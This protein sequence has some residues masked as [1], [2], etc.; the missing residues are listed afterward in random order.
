MNSAERDRLETTLRENLRTN[1][2]GLREL[3]ESVSSEFGY[4]DPVYRFYHQS[5]KVFSLQ[6][7]TTRIVQTLQALLPGRPLHPWFQ[8]VVADGTGKTFDPKSNA[9]WLAETRPIVEA[10]FHARYFLDMACRYSHAPEEELM[11]SG[12]VAVLSLYDLR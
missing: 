12:W 1:A 9:H 4:E 10:F 3:F 8:A 2:G 7:T 11:A 6:S 5:F